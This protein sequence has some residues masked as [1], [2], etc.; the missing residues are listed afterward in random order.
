MTEGSLMG[1]SHQLSTKL[2][3]KLIVAIVELV[4][5]GLKV[6]TDEID[7]CNVFVQSETFRSLSLCKFLF[8]IDSK[9]GLVARL[10][11]SSQNGVMKLNSF[12]LLCPQL[13]LV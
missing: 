4:F 6:V 2:S 11:G 5:G 8:E 7:I 13:G 1:C 12:G 9:E 3:N 10:N